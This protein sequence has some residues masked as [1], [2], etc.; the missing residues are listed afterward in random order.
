M[1]AESYLEEGGAAED[2]R[3]YQPVYDRVGL[4]ASSL[5][6][7]HCI[8]MPWVIMVMPIIAG[9]ILTNATAENI[10]VGVSLLDQ[11]T[12]KN[13]IA[14]GFSENPSLGHTTRVVWVW[15]T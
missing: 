10:F 3:A 13:R 1:E 15:L 12:T 2:I 7:V 9:T 11:N 14:N 5:C 4:I 8:L 6:A